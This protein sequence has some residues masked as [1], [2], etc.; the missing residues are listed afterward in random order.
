MYTLVADRILTLVILLSMIVG[1]ILAYRSAIKGTLHP[2]IRRIEALEHIDE[3]IG[4]AYEMGKPIHFTGGSY[5][6]NSQYAPQ[7]VAGVSVLD[8]MAKKCA[9]LD[10][11]IK[12]TVG[13]AENIPLTQDVLEQAYATEG[14]SDLYSAD[15]IQFF[16]SG[17]RSFGTGTIKYLEDNR[18]GCNVMVGPF[19]AD[20]MTLSEVSQKIGAFT[21]GGTARLVQMPFFM[22]AC[23]YTLICDEMYSV[24]AYL[25]KNPASLSSIFISDLFKL[26]TN[27]VIILS[28]I[29]ATLGI[30]GLI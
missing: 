29:T 18:P 6:I 13:R 22:L 30:G 7:V 24:S 21:I 9:Q 25:T 3:A 2:E 26:A 16:G 17:G 15:Q 5:S 28:I 12:V 8:Y 27:A 19:A 1:A 23:D 4:R 10:T 14:K 20:S 11:K